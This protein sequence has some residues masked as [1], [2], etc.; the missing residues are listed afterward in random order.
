MKGS[1]EERGWPYSSRI[2]KGSPHCQGLPWQGVAPECGF[3]AGYYQ[4]GLPEMPHSGGQSH[5]GSDCLCADP[6][7]PF[8]ASA[9]G[10]GWEVAHSSKEGSCREAA[11]SGGGAGVA[12]HACV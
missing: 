12:G 10:R 5:L 3:H 11:V 4:R 7:C 6:S 8:L 1:D 9:G 2:L